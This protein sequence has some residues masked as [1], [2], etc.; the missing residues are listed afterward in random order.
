MPAMVKRTLSV[1]STHRNGRKF[2]EKRSPAKN[3]DRP[4]LRCLPAF[5][6][7]E[8]LGVRAPA[9]DGALVAGVLG[10]T[11]DVCNQGRGC[12]REFL[13]L[14]DCKHVMVCAL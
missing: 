4:P 7:P 6:L 12:E 10:A 14:R 13:C 3:M 11:L 5:L 1:P 2:S 9:R 8:L